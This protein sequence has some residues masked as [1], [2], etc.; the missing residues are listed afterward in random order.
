MKKKII[1]SSEKIFSRSSITQIIKKNF[2]TK[3]KTILIV[4]VERG[5]TS[6][7]AGVV[8]ALGL[9]GGERLGRNHES[10]AFLNDNKVKLLEN[11]KFMKEQ[12]DIWWIKM[13]KLSLDLE[14]ILSN[15]ENPIII[16]VNRN[17]TA[18]ANSWLQRSNSKPIKTFK[19]ILSY[20]SE[21]IKIVA[22]KN[23]PT[24][25]VDYEYS[26]RNPEKFVGELV[27]FLK[28]KFDDDKIEKAVGMINEDGGGYIDIP[29][30]NFTVNTLD[31]KTQ[32]L[33]ERKKTRIFKLQNLNEFIK[34]ESED[35]KIEIKLDENLSKNLIMNIDVKYHNI[36]MTEG[37]ILRVYADYNKGFIPIHAHRPLLV[38]GNNNLVITFD[39]IPK[40]IGLGVIGNSS[41]SFK[42]NSLKTIEDTIGLEFIS[43]KY[44]KPK[45]FLFL[46]QIII[47]AIKKVN[48]L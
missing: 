39:N 40:R 4:G 43:Q 9:Y 10:T 3:K 38:N 42:I 5:G 16:F 47:N 41:L 11:I 2:F 32:N 26:C 23:I 44:F 30:F 24:I 33:I 34:L 8:R 27:N 6:M 15:V 1:N 25:S 17:W 18:I 29:E 21:I 37:N 12:S 45:K 36:L 13:P 19:H 22:Q 46:K 20:Y 14:F 48:F 28:I 7:V 35:K 31:F